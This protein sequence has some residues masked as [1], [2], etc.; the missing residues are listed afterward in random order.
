M[1]TEI[2]LAVLIVVV[3]RYSI[4]YVRWIRRANALT[5]NIGCWPTIPFFGHAYKFLGN[6]EVLFKRLQELT[7]MSEKY[8]GRFKVWM[9]PTLLIFTTVPE[10]IKVINNTFINKPFIYKFAKLWVGDGIA[11]APAEIWKKTINRVNNAFSASVTDGFQDVYNVYARKLVGQLKAESGR[12]A[13]DVSRT[14]SFVILQAI[15]HTVMGV[16]NIDDMV[17]REDY[18]NAFNNAALLLINRARNPLYYPDFIYKLT[19]SYKEF[20]ENVNI[21]HSLSSWIVNKKRNEAIEM[22]KNGMTEQI[23]KDTGRP[24]FRSLLDNLLDATFTDPTLTNEQVQGDADNF[25]AA[26]Y[27]TTSVTVLFILLMI[28]SHPDVQEKLY[29]EMKEVFGE[30]KRDV[31]K[32]DLGRL[33]YTEAVVSETLR[34]LPVVPVVMRHADYDLKLDGWTVPKGAEVVV[35]PWGTCQSRLNWGED[36]RKFVPERW[37]RD[38]QPDPIAFNAFSYGRRICIAKHS[39][40]VF[41]KIII[42]QCI[43]ELKFKAQIEKLRIQMNVTLYPMAGEGKNLEVTARN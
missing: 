15:C 31:T 4:Q 29:A 12:P 25:I 21:I 28:G 2:L 14:I 17:V 11:C 1:L 18:Y 19:P 5:A 36:A 6:T 41:L 43:R 26:G 38:N 34:M 40:M 16:K 7:D 10:D 42:A 35:F 9:G 30:S 37:F 33:K 27:E 3:L 32:D 13:F 24:E 8:G 39:A 22:R 23:D 20:K